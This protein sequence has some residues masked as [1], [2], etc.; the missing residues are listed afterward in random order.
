MEGC[1]GA[2]TPGMLDP[3]DAC[4]AKGRLRQGE[5]SVG[6]Q[7]QARLE[8][9]G[10]SCLC[11]L[12]SSLPGGPWVL[13]KQDETLGGVGAGATGPWSPGHSWPGEGW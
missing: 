2:W 3:R 6:G 11:V 10:P 7:D 12:T 4:C 9:P 1:G 13:G 5:R 8:P